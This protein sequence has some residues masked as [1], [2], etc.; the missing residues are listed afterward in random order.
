MAAAAALRVHCTTACLPEAAA[1]A[2]SP[3]STLSIPQVAFL[4]CPACSR[5]GIARHAAGNRLLPA[6]LCPWN[7]VAAPPPCPCLLQD[8]LNAQ[9]VKCDASGNPILKDVGTWLRSEMKRHFKDA[10][11]K[12]IDPS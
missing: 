7:H 8:T 3:F 2:L 4:S 5:G 10:D 6:L 12:Y 9:E 1:R 11:I